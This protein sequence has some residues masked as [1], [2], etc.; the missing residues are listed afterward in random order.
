M[1]PP[2]PPPVPVVRAHAQVI[3]A[4]NL[5]TWSHAIIRTASITSFFSPVAKRMC[6]PLF[7][8]LDS[9]LELTINTNWGFN[10]LEPDSL[11][12]L[13]KL[14][15]IAH[16]QCPVV[17]CML[18]KNFTGFKQSIHRLQFYRC[19]YEYTTTPCQ[20]EWDAKRCSKQIND[21]SECLIIPEIGKSRTIITLLV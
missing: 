17:C 5:L 2:P 1:P 18:A 4:C 14:M 7:Y 6:L 20:Y 13:W 3:A 19:D 12:S 11:F 21:P 15:H 9:P 8:I 10:S 16:L